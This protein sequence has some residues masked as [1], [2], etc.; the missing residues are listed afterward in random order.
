METAKKKEP[1]GFVSSIKGSFMTDPETGIKYTNNE[2]II[3][4]RS[5]TSYKKALGIIQ[6]INGKVVGG[7]D[8]LGIYQIFIP[9]VDLHGL[10]TLEN[11]LNNMPEVDFVETNTV[12]ANPLDIRNAKLAPDQIPAVTDVWPQSLSWD[13]D[14]P[15]PC[16]NDEDNPLPNCQNWWVT[17]VQAPSAWDY[18]NRFSHITLGVIDDGFYSEHEDLKG[19][20][21]FPTSIQAKENHQEMHGTFVSGIIGARAD[22]RKGIAG[23]VW[24]TTLLCSAWKASEELENENW[25]NEKKVFDWLYRASLGRS[26]GYKFFSR[27]N[28]QHG[29]WS[30]FLV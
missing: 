27:H 19:V 25:D 26:K 24:D 6:Q 5:G 4:F 7:V 10:Y 22:N 17:A 29:K 18:S 14:R 1:A 2:L 28:Q 15:T 30:I 11:H 12:S 3:F 23:I 20:L 9:P 13:E 21:R 16:G 8:E